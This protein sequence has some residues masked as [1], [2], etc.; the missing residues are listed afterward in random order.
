MKFM[1]IFKSQFYQL[2][3]VCSLYQVAETFSK[4][5]LIYC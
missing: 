3:I 5:Y 4:L 1:Y 2:N